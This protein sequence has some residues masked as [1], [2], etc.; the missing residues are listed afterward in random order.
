MLLGCSPG[1]AADGDGGIAATAPSGYALAVGSVRFPSSEVLVVGLTLRNDTI[2]AALGTDSAYF[3]VL[4]TNHVVVRPASGPSSSTTCK[5]SLAVAAGGSLN[6]ELEL[7]LPDG[8]FPQA[9]QYDDGMGHS[10][11]ATIPPNP[12]FGRWRGDTLFRIEESQALTLHEDGTIDCTVSF[13]IPETATEFAGCS[14]TDVEKG[15]TL[16]VSPGGGYPQTERMFFFPG[17]GT[18]TRSSC[19][20]PADNT[21]P[22]PASFVPL[23]FLVGWSTAT[24]GADTMT[25]SDSYGHLNSFTKL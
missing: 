25:L 1:T 8:T 4:L 2:A 18:V 13:K 22:V 14:E 11:S 24:F 3:S 17:T 23:A 10:A 19:R 16:T 6:C 9:L 12:A 20:A 21:G 5:A 7:D 15:G